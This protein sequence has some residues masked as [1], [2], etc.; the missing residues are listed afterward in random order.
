MKQNREP[1]NKP[2]HLWS[3]NLQQRRQDHKM[4]KSLS[5][6][7]CWE[8]W[9]APCKSM[10]LEHTLT[11]CTEIKR[12]T[13]LNVRHDAIKLLEESIGKTFSDIVFYQASLPRNK[14]KYKPM[15]TNHIYKF[16]HSK[17]NHTQNKKTTYEMEEISANNATDKG[18]ISK[19]YK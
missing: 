8:N 19:I 12:L 7:W 16:L 2:R 15:G 3:L 10:K 6:K 9:T 14:N 1:R 11:R 17:G 13:D 18:L 5:S 4:G